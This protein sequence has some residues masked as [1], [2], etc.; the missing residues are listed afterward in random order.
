MDRISEIL[1]RIR[2]I[3]AKIDNLDDTIKG[4]FDLCGEMVDAIG[5]MDEQYSDVLQHAVIVVDARK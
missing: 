2:S 5:E 4:C 1:H 3:E